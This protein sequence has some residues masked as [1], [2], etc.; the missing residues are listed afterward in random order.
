[1]PK[2]PLEIK[3][4][5]V[6]EKY[7][8]VLK[9]NSSKAPT[10]AKKMAIDAVVEDLKSEMSEEGEQYVLDVLE[11]VAENN[12]DLV[13]ELL[14]SLDKFRDVQL[15]ARTYDKSLIAN[16]E[17]EGPILA[18]EAV[19]SLV[20]DMIEK[21]G[22]KHVQ[23]VLSELSGE[24][25]SDIV[26][27]IHITDDKDR[28]FPAELVETLLE[29]VALDRMAAERRE[30]AKKAGRV[31]NDP[32]V[33]VEGVGQARRRSVAS[34]PGSLESPNSSEAHPALTRNPSTFELGRGVASKAREMGV[35]P[36]NDKAPNGPVPGVIKPGGLKL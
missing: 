16:L 21:R 33:I 23:A 1:M 8:Q 25:I 10:V 31:V 11:K 6:Q 30:G 4:E 22:L 19:Q 14:G 34:D 12:K 35:S 5:F 32:P 28:V 13:F 26:G 7:S 2:D 18:Q 29:N 17:P 36:R 24:K 15:I 27:P 9:E 20:N 3:A